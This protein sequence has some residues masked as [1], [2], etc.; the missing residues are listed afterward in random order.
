MCRRCSCTV[1]R[2]R[3]ASPCTR[4]TSVFTR[5]MTPGGAA[6]STSSGDDDWHRCDVTSPASSSCRCSNNVSSF[7]LITPGPA[8]HCGLKHK[9]RV[10]F[11]HYFH[12][13]TTL[14]RWI[15][16][17]QVPSL[18]S[19]SSTRFRTVPLRT[20]GTGFL[21]TGC[22]SCHPTISVEA[23][24]EIQSIIIIVWLVRCWT[25]TFRQARK[26]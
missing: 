4:R 12:L 2:Q 26:L 1:P 19:S 15:W 11:Y 8:K 17:S 24:K 9:N 14:S 6:I 22:P 13:M 10:I 16:V 25:T 3:C 20:N 18:G 5:D 21:R 7:T 23:T